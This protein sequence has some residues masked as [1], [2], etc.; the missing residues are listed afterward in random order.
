MIGGIRVEMA[1]K[2]YC[3]RMGFTS[4]SYLGVNCMTSFDFYG[5][6]NKRWTVKFSRSFVKFEEILKVVYIAGFGI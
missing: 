5:T 2:R 4:D 6:I 1:K 3:V